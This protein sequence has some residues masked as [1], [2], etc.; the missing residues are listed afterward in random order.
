M[1]KIR[2]LKKEFKDTGFCIECRNLDVTDGCSIGIYGDTGSGKTLFSMLL[3]GVI[4]NYSGSV[5]IDITELKNTFRK[6]IGYVPFGNIL[7][8]ALTVGEMSKFMMEQY[9]IKK[10]E[11][12]LKIQWFDQFFMISE[13]LERKIS[14][15][16]S[17]QLQFVK[18]FNA[19]I[20]SPSVLIIDEP[21]NGPGSSA[22]GAFRSLLSDLKER[23]VSV[24]AFS[25]HKEMIGMV[26]DSTVNIIN[27][28]IE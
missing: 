12:D 23:N 2:D 10:T 15:L 13:L 26:T 27:G 16:S 14:T 18:L 1:I 5:M 28:K 9:K 3:S 19:L 7:Y 6:K 11:L 8:P 22:V 24:I 20:H 4:K 25:A 21:F 17:G